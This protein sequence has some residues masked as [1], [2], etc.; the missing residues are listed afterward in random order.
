MASL[1]KIRWG[2]LLQTVLESCDDPQNMPC[3]IQDLLD[4]VEL[5]EN[6]KAIPEILIFLQS[7]HGFTA[8]EADYLCSP[9]LD[10]IYD[11][12]GVPKRSSGA[13]LRLPYCIL[14]NCCT[15]GFV[16]AATFFLQRGAVVDAYYNEPLR[17]AV[18]SGNL[19][20]TRLLIENGAQASALSE[21]LIQ[22]AIVDHRL[23]L[24]QYLLTKGATIPSHLFL[25]LQSAPSDTD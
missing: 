23:E 19:E 20:M 1:S 5:L 14:S 8:L 17:F 4:R 18:S 10:H 22:K 2:G 3:Q 16:D 12:T 21:S 7:E 13:R 25:D 6:C 9:L 11:S 15:L 24:V